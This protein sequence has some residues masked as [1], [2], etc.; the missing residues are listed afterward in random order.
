MEAALSSLPGVRILPTESASSASFIAVDVPLK[1]D[2]LQLARLLDG[3]GVRL[4]RPYAPDHDP[5]VSL[6]PT[7]YMVGNPFHRLPGP[8]S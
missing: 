2:L 5:H 4:R 6:R 1:E 3:M 8:R 7:T